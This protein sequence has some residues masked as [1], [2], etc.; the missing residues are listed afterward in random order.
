MCSIV[1]AAGRQQAGCNVFCT[2]M[3][4]RCAQ[5]STLLGSHGSLH[6]PCAPRADGQAHCPEVAVDGWRSVLWTVL[7]RQRCQS[8]TSLQSPPP[9]CHLQRRS[10][11]VASREQRHSTSAG[12]CASGFVPPCIGWGDDGPRPSLLIRSHQSVDPNASD[13]QPATH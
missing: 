4:P 9:W 6:A 10:P 3:L 13:S 7:N 12:P 2:A 8:S 11:V 1:N 5:S